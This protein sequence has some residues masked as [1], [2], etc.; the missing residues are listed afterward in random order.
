M[1]IM[2]AKEM[3]ENYKR[4]HLAILEGNNCSQ[5]LLITVMHHPGGTSTIDF[6]S[7]F[8]YIRTIAYL[9]GRITQGLRAFWRER[10]ITIA[11]LVQIVRE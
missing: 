9:S 3:T 11:P 2:N 4:N 8:F 5:L 1:E 10:W 7:E 6:L